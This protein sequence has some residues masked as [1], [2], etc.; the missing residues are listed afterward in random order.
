[1]YFERIGGAVESITDTRRSLG[2]FPRL[3]D[4]LHAHHCL[5]EQEDDRNRNEQDTDDVNDDS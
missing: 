4:R 5:D 3:P 2:D 1:M